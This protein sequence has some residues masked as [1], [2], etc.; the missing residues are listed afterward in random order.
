MM[1]AY[2]ARR[3]TEQVFDTEKEQDRRFRTSDPVT[4]KGSYFIQFTAQIM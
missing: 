3:L 2:D 4:L 1:A